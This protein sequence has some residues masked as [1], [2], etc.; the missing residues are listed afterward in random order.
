MDGVGV[1]VSVEQEKT[2]FKIEP[3]RG[4]GGQAAIVDPDGNVWWFDHNDDDGTI[5]D[6]C[7]QLNKAQKLIPGRSSAG[8]RLIDMPPVERRAYAEG[9]ADGYNDAKN[10]A[11]GPMRPG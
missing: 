4:S 1:E 3:D 7:E 6:V 2:Y 9:F 5:E 10:V 11:A 8:K